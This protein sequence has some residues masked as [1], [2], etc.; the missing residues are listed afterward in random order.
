MSVAAQFEAKAS[1]D[2]SSPFYFNP[3]HWRAMDGI[4]D[5]VKAREGIMVMTGPTG[6][7]KTML[8]RAI[9]DSLGEGVTPLFLQYASLNFR[10]FVNFL[11]NSLNVSDEVLDASNKAVALRKFLYAQAERNETA[12]VFIDEAQNVEPDVLRML[13]KLACFDQLENGTNV[14]LQFML[15]GGSEL[16]ELLRDDDFEEV[17]DAIARRYEL[18]FFTREELKYFLEKRLSPLARL[19]PEPITE[20][21]INTVGKFTGGSP[22]LMGMI[23]SHAMLFAAEN[24]GRSI[25]E[26]MIEEAAEALMI[27]PVENPFAHEGDTEAE[28]SGPFSSAEIRG[29]A[30]STEPDLAD[31]FG[32]E[33]AAEEVSM[34]TMD[35]PI[36]PSVDDSY[37][38]DSLFDKRDSE[39]FE[40]EA[41][42]PTL[43]SVMDEMGIG[44]D[45]DGGHDEWD[46]DLAEAD[47]TMGVAAGAGVAAVAGA[48]SGSMLG[49][50]KSAFARGKKSAVTDKLGDV[51]DAGLEAGSDMFE[52][53]TGALKDTVGSASAAGDSVMASAKSAFSPRKKLDL[54]GSA[55]DAVDAGLDKGSDMLATG[56][57]ALKDTVGSASAVGGS[58]LGKANSVLSRGKKINFSEQVGSIADAGKEMGGDML[59]AGTGAITGA[60][61]TVGATGDSAMSG[62]KSVFSGGRKKAKQAQI[63]GAGR[64]GPNT[65]RAAAPVEKRAMKTRVAGQRKQQL[66]YAGA[67]AAFCALA[68]GAYMIRTDV[69]NVF[70]RATDSVKSTASSAINTASSAIDKVATVGSGAVGSLTTGSDD[71]LHVETP[72]YGSSV[73]LASRDVGSVAVEVPPASNGIALPLPTAPKAAEPVKTGGWGANVEV[74][75]PLLKLPNLSIPDAPKLPDAGVGLARGALDLVESA[76]DKGQEVLPDDMKAALDVAKGDVQNLRTAATLNGATESE[77]VAK[78]AELVSEGDDFFAKQLYIAPRGGN[79]YDAYRAAL[80]LDPQNAGAAKGLEKLRAFYSKKAEA[81]RAQ[82]QWDRANRHFETALAISQ[83]KGVR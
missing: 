77:R 6:S 51:A 63:V 62:I 28:L 70:A 76:I 81:A 35:A 72:S 10:E 32:V 53:G 50:V 26:A 38:D 57:G 59:D 74:S 33:A 2:L 42:A 29:D 22:R 37:D 58:V 54:T 31:Q 5:G 24:P 17:R 55:S 12:V 73:E 71:P 45:V 13:P 61:G 52:A 8:M 4:V 64:K 65:Q 3:S 41:D 15:T 68:F 47:S 9:S 27:D 78:V 82:K 56:T 48:A 49:R 19:T 1:D 43:S 83:R 20:E 23:C 80:D 40:G 16:H 11:H 7:G 75:Q 69:S 66:K 46:D 30:T 67:A 14:G 34:T 18:R 25:D 79:A 44:L 60:V 39:S 21:A 36:A